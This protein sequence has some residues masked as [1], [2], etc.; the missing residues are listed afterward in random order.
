MRHFAS[1]QPSDA[2]DQVSNMPASPDDSEGRGN[3]RLAAKTLGGLI[4]ASPRFVVVGCCALV[5]LCGALLVVHPLQL[6]TDP[7]QLWAQPGSTS[8]KDKAFFDS[9]YGPFW[10]TEMLIVSNP[11]GGKR[12]VGYKVLSSL[13]DLQLK[14]EGI[15]VKC[16]ELPAEAGKLPSYCEAGE[17]WGLDELCFQPVPGGGCLVQSALEFWQMNR[18]QLDATPGCDDPARTDDCDQALGAYMDVC[19]E[20]GTGRREC[21]ARN[22]MPLT[23]AGVL[24]G[25]EGNVPASPSRADA[26]VVTYLLNNDEWAAPRA[27]AWERQLRMLIDDHKGPLSG[28]KVSYSTEDS[29]TLELAEESASDVG[30]ICVS[31]IVMFVYVAYALG[32]HPPSCADPPKPRN[33]AI[34]GLCGVVIVGM[35]LVAAASV[36]S[37]LGVRAT[38]IISEVIP[39]LILAI[40]VDNIFI[41]VWAFDGTST[42][43]STSQRAGQTLE[44]VGPSIA[45]AATAE[46]LAFL[47]G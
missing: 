4:G 19:V 16:S 12:T 38:L 36:C 9:E 29:L 2:P 8:A 3:I 17:E 40:G 13:L 21:W 10:R 31:Y 46:S 24:F 7:A 18:S 14:A 37:L 34:L 5:L 23:E 11:H 27:A 15:R 41:L 45:C 44:S 35:S 28:L 32:R 30:T 26:I 42:N 1:G 47:L 20:E 6:L 33:R 22:G 39:F 43:D 25:Y